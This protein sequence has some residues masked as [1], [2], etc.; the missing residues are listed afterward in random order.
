MMTEGCPPNPHRRTIEIYAATSARM[1][2]A[3]LGQLGAGLTGRYT[4]ERELG[5][6]GHVYRVPGPRPEAPPQGGD[7]S[8]PARARPRCSA[9]NDSPARSA[10]P[11]GSTH[12]HILPLDTTLAR[13][14]DSSSMFDALRRA[15]SPCDTSSPGKDSSRST[16]RS[17]SCARSPSALEHAHGHGLI[18]RDIKP[19]NILLHEGDAMVTDFGI[20]AADSGSAGQRRQQGT[21]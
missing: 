1:T 17:V 21:E 20:A 19:E 2:S 3:Q 9:P 4:V 13:W 15:V 5:R 6:G 18:H 14:T 12:P 7:Q 10:S 16:R 8:A 11:P